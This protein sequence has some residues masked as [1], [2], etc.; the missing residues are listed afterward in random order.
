M[1]TRASLW[2]A[3]LLLLPLSARAQESVPHFTAAQVEAGKEVF[4]RVCFV[5]HKA[6]LSGTEIAPPLKGSSFASN[7]SGQAA[8]EL[9]EFVMEEMP[10]TAPGSLDRDSYVRVVAYILSFN[11]MVAGPTELTVEDPGIIRIATK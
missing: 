4:G 10:Q 1:M 2:G 11:G 7:W 5:C 8:E 6:D 9:L 3:V